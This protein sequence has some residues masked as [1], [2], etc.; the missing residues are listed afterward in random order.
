MNER[1]TSRLI[2]TADDVG[3]HPGMTEGA[4][5]AAE[6]GI[7]T[8]CSVV[9]NG[10]DSDAA[11][12]RLSVLGIDVGVHLTLVEERPL[13]AR[14]DVPSLLGADGRFLPSYRELAV[15]YLSGRIAIADVERELRAQIEKVLR[16][17]VAVTHMNGHQH[18]H[19]LPAIFRTV[20]RL[21]EE[22]KIGYVR[23]PSD[24]VAGFTVRSAA[25]RAL[26]HLGVRARQQVIEGSIRTNNRTIGIVE[27]GHLNR[28]SI[29]RLLDSVEGVTELVCH[30]GIDNRAIAARYRWR[31]DWDSETDALCDITLRQEIASRGIQLI[32]PRDL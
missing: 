10:A 21:A 31:Y 17:G 30:P 4:I 8:A 19:V 18:L 5:Q 27:A 13:C 2:V 11:L 32:A 28:A 3:L 9:A 7:V 6:R 26:N 24:P 15:R 25:I 29:V 14:S 20:L 22:F 16:A 23:I 12:K 1:S